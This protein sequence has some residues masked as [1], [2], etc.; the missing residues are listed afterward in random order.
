MAVR[1]S[2]FSKSIGG[3]CKFSNVRSSF[4]GI[5]S[6]APQKLISV[7][8][9]IITFTLHNNPLPWGVKLTGYTRISE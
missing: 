7:L 2:I 3:A 9:V 4:F 6:A 5:P 8:P 1:R